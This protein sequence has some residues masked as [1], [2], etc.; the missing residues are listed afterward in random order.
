MGFFLRNFHIVVFAV[1]S[2]GAGAW[3]SS[4]PD[5]VVGVMEPIV[6]DAVELGEI[7]S[8]VYRSAENI[9]WRASVEEA[10]TMYIAALRM[11]SLLFERLETQLADVDRHLKSLG[12]SNA[13]PPRKKLTGD[14]KLS[15]LKDLTSSRSWQF[16]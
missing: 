9:D 15:I 16:N 14:Q 6:A 4:D 11:P 8:A 3:V 12:S 13:A 2:L 10:M 1:V 5:R 7:T